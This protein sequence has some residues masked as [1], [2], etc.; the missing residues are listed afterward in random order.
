MIVRSLRRQPTTKVEQRD[1]ALN[2]ASWSQFLARLSGG[3]SMSMDSAMRHDA[4]WAC[5][6]L[7]AKDIAKMP[8][9]A[10]RYRGGLKVPVPGVP[11]L[12]QPSAAATT[13]DWLYQIMVSLQLRGN[14]YGLI[15][16][17]DDRVAM[18]R[19]VEIVSPDDVTWQGGRPFYDGKA[20]DL[21]P[22]GRMWHLP[23]FTM[24]G[25]VE[26]MSPISHHART[27]ATGQAV[28]EF[29]A[30]F[31]ESNASPAAILTSRGNP[32]PE[33]AQQLKDR[34]RAVLSGN[35]REPLVLPEGTTW[36]PLQ[37]NPEE[38]QFLDTQ[39]LT[40]EQV[41]RVFGVPPSRVGASVTGGGSLTYSNRESDAL[42][43]LESSLQFWMTKIETAISQLLPRGM[44]CKFNPGV[45]LRTDLAGRYASY[46]VAA[47]I[48]AITGQTLLSV[49]E[50]RE[51]ED[52][53]PLDMPVEPDAVEGGPDGAA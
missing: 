16:D 24:P 12:E 28:Q 4:V 41:C 51:L 11:L 47:E 18:A 45:I 44:R 23:A 29:A 34:V 48:G 17:V 27:I 36:V 43:Y 37:I 19:T 32:T 2:I 3:S 13:V 53:A 33:Q 31:F 46:K 42:N 26:G 5:V 25:A 50:M 39:R 22:V 15:T 7:L 49:D 30:A 9:D 40:V 14:A 52:R 6:N 38:S 8:L 10:I 1:G 35:R 21:W 20:W